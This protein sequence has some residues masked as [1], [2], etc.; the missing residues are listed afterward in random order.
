MKRSFSTLLLCWGASVTALVSHGATTNWLTY[1]PAPPDNPLKG[2]VTYPGPRFAFP[3]SLVWNYLS[4]RSLMTGPTNFNWEPLEAELNAAARQG[5]Q[6]IPRFH[7]DFPGQP[8]AIPQFLIDAG[9]RVRIWTNTNT[10]PWP[11]AVSYT[12]D[13]QDARTRAAL[14]N[15]IHALGAR[16]DGDARLA[17]LPMGLL[18]TWGEWHNS[19]H[20]EWFAS[21]TVQREVMDAY[22]A[23]FNTTRILAR[24]P[25]GANDFVYASNA[26]RPLGYHDDSFAWATMETVRPGDEWFFRSR[27]IRAGAVD[28]WREHPIGGEVRPEVWDCLWNETTCAPPG[29]EFDRCATHTHATWLANH[30]VFQGK[31][32]GDRLE[33]A[34][35]AARLLG[36]E[37][38]VA[39]V[40]IGD[41]STDAPLSVG[42]TV[43]N[44]GIAPFYYDWSVELGVID[45]SGMLLKTWPLAHR[46]TGILP[47]GP[48]VAWDHRVAGLALVPGSYHLALRAVHPLP[49]G[50][51]LRF[52]NQSQDQHRAGWLALGQLRV[53]ARPRL[54][55]E[56]QSDG[57]LNLEILEPASRPLRLESS[58]DL[59]VW[60][61][62]ASGV[63]PFEGLALSGFSR[64]F[65]VR[66]SP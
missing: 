15:F 61:V 22:G 17:F 23:A 41:A 12:P 14:T 20:D 39:R 1:A 9:V 52:A 34:L 49:N 63:P 27:L 4:L 28:K 33:R 55:A 7:M 10:Q 5:R 40:V 3:H 2:F 43:T 18:G 60:Q 54:R 47:G 42:L 19:P 38:H 30:G 24:Y 46:L 32:D 64:F 57:R 11:P 59:A 6:F 36:Y 35:A 58:S 65:R 66:I 26:Q 53:E 13:Y 45:A 8:I 50:K 51:P 56:I 21:K 62:V 16:Y 29:Q 44:T 37:F 31:L 48:A 25:A